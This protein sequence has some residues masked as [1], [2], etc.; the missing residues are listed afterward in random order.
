MVLTS[1]HR[2]LTAGNSLLL[3]FNVSHIHCA[4]SY[5]EHVVLRVKLQMG[6]AYHHY[7]YSD[8]ISHSDRATLIQH[9]DVR[10]G[11]ITIDLVSPFGTTSHLLPHRSRD[12]VNSEGFNY[13]PFMSVRHWGEFPR[14]QWLVNVSYTPQTH[15]RG[16]VLLQSLELNLFGT[17]QVAESVLAIPASCD[18][19]C[20][21]SCGG[22]GPLL[23]DVCR[24]MRNA[25]TLECVD[26]CSQGDREQGKYCFPPGNSSHS[27]PATEE[28]EPWQSSGPG[29]LNV[30]ASK[31][32]AYSSVVVAGSSCT[33]ILGSLAVINISLSLFNK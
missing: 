13:W 2:V 12:F 25:V 31:P 21:G 24:S 17:A 32:H 4:M 11:D 26:S 7:S 22:E 1:C 5:L 29:Q 23:C 8:Y 3:L 9:N 27:P 18:E 6:G 20:V 15:R 19:H 16:Y 30:V 28:S 10:R 14:G 33:V